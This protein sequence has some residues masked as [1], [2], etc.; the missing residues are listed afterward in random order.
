MRSSGLVLFTCA[1]LLL[2]G[3]AILGGSA[4]WSLLRMSYYFWTSDLG[5]ELSS[6]VLLIAGALLCLP[7][8][9][10]ATTVP[11]HTK[12]LSLT[13]TLMGL[14]SVAMVTVGMGMSSLSGLSRA[15]REPAMLNNSMLR[16]M[17]VDA[18]DPAVRS[19]F[20]AMQTELRCCGVQSYAD[21]YLHRRTLPPACCGR[22]WNGKVIPKNR[23]ETCEVPM[24]SMGCLR[25]ALAEL[26]YFANS[27]TALSSA[28]VIVMAVTLFATVYLLATG[29][30]ERGSWRVSKAPPALRVA[31]LS[32]APPP[33]VALTTPAPLPIDSAL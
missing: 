8:C 30:V 22:V 26:R 15:L 1:G 32:H 17:A 9:W 25:P 28:I 5:V 7:I 18:F 3:G 14:V 27:L 4:A 20:A 6:S 24:Y 23:G 21:W 19:S 10:L 2:S 13:A 11:Y 29:V 33:L 12:S 16:A 31:C